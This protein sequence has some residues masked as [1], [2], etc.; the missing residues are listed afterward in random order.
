MKLCAASGTSWTLIRITAARSLCEPVVSDLVLA[1][2]DQR[3]IDGHGG[4]E[5]GSISTLRFHWSVSDILQPVVPPSPHP[6][7]LPLTDTP[8]LPLPPF[9][10]ACNT[11]YTCNDCSQVAA[12]GRARH[13]AHAPPL[14]QCCIA[15]IHTACAC[16]MPLCHTL[17][18]VTARPCLE[19]GRVA[20]RLRWLQLP[21]CARCAA[22]NLNCPAARQ[23][24]GGRRHRVVALFVPAE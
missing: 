22:G 6:L 15:A 9:L 2:N 18:R 20:L 10:S 24:P 14:L 1:V 12:S 21:C 4:R 5:C 17:A 7:P 8:S 3:G 23:T 16:T 19:G 11:A 13:A